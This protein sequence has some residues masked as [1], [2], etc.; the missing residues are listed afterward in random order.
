MVGWAAAAGFGSFPDTQ[1]T[2][3]CFY[4]DT[5][6]PEVCAQFKHGGRPTKDTAISNVA[7]EVG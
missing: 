7:G 6:E 2:I 1:K 5:S 4:M 3:T